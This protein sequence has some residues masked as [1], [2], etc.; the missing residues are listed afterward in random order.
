MTRSRSSRRGA[1]GMGAA[2][3]RMLVAEGAK[4]VIGD[5]LD[6]RGQASPTSSATPPAT[7]TSTSPTRRTGQAAVDTAVTEFGTLNVLVNN[8]GIVHVAPL[9]ALQREKWHGFST[10]TSPAPCWASR[11]RSSR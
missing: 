4:V 7:S 8:A 10:S 6:E 2:D 5:L 11:R 1:R 9:K 3:A